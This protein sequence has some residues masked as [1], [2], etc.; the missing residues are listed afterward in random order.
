MKK[1]NKLIIV[2][3][4]VLI[5]IQSNAVGM[6]DAMWYL[7]IDVNQ[8]TNNEFFKHIH[9]QS[10]ARH[11][12]LETIPKEIEF[13]TLYGGDARDSD[14][15]TVVIRGNFTQFSVHDFALDFIL[16]KK[17]NAAK[18]I[19]ESA[20]SYAGNDIQVLTVK[21]E[22]ELNDNT[23]AKKVYYFSAI[24]DKMSVV[25]LDLDEVKNWIDNADSPVD[26]NDGKIFS[27]STNVKSVLAHMGV[28]PVRINPM[29]D[30]AIFKSVT[31]FS[32]SVTE[33]NAD[34]V[35]EV[36]LT[37]DD[38]ATATQIQQVVSGL[39]AMNNLSGANADSPLHAMFIQNLTIEKNE[40]IVRINTFG[41]IDKLKRINFNKYLKQGNGVKPEANTDL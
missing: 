29:L 34:I 27:V 6:K 31:E 39:I 26:F 23:K 35:L 17:E 33:V 3:V 13:I 1:I 8:V 30:S 10:S 20:L 9:G 5:S 32:V 15:A 37:S 7:S 22:S 38:M 18:L 36:T 25:S 12:D 21:D 14:E 24:N 41:A 4:T 28:D 19:T 16:S 2:L 40:N 11:F